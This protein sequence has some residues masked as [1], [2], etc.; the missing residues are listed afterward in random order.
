MRITKN[1]PET[2]FVKS[3]ALI[4][5]EYF[6][7][8]MCLCVIAIRAVSIEGPIIQLANQPVNIG[9]ST[10]SLIISEILLFSF[11]SWLI[12]NFLGKRFLYRL[13]TLEI[14][15]ALFIIAAIISSCVAP[16]KRAAI[17]TSVS[18]LA[19]IF[20]AILFIQILDSPAKIKFVL[21]TIVGVGLLSAGYCFIQ[22]IWI[23]PAL[24]SDYRADPNVF[25]QKIGIEPGSFHQM[26]LEHSLY[27][28]DIR[29]FFTTGNSAGSFAL[30]T[31]FAAAALLIENL[32]NKRQ[33]HRKLKIALS[34]IACCFI[35]FGLV[36]THSK[37]AIIATIFG[38]TLFLIYFA[39]SDWLFSHKKSVIIIFILCA[40]AVGSFA[41]WFGLTHDRL[42]GGNSMLVRWQYWQASA[43]MYADH[44]FAG[45]GPG[46][47]AYF[48]SHYKPASAPETVSDPHN[49]LL[50]FLLQFGP[51]GLAGFLLM[52]LT[53]LAA[54]IFVPANQNSKNENGYP[55]KT[56]IAV[57]TCAILAFLFHNM[58]DFAIF[59]A[60]VWTVLWTLIA[61]LISLCLQ[62]FVVK[63]PVPVRFLLAAASLFLIWYSFN[64]VLMPV[65]KTSARINI[66]ILNPEYSSDYLANAVH[67]DL[68]D[69]IP[70]NLS[71]KFYLAQFTQTG[72]KD[73]ALLY[74]AEESF[75]IASNRNKADFKYHE[76]LIEVYKLLA[77]S[78]SGQAKTNWLNKAFESAKTAV[79]LYPGSDRLNFE[80]AK[81]AENL[82]KNDV[83]IEHYKK[84]VEIEDSYRKQFQTMYPGRKMFSRLGEKSY[85]YAK[86][87]IKST[88]QN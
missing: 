53:P 15:L 43:Q 82:D 81:L 64:Y 59:E 46:N 1:K 17:T 52:A 33:E 54:A 56:V 62:G 5:F 83:A 68:F 7:F 41:V 61:C 65:A 85:E 71:G 49:F 60:P 88:S 79:F 69:P 3:R 8:A 25:L 27:S 16:N 42:P 13:T 70:A 78:S 57:L 34:V 6:L 12:F 67:E 29:G 74:K 10:F 77:E 38:A 14:G 32:K 66:A 31:A 4:L 24:L 72:K 22:F 28:N 63:I 30:L 84:T 80:L 36:L 47:F 51:L 73:I 55:S 75:I 44:P 20:M 76:N 87:K 48:Y 26:L 19:P 50:S 35:V 23:N 39:A 45:V 11:L 18:L 86:E 21:Y 2:V 58:I 9:D 40:M 37:G